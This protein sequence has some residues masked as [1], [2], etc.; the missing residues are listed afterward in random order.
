M[1]RILKIVLI[2]LL[3]ALIVIQFIKPTKNA[4]AEIATHQVT[5]AFNVPDTVHQILKVSCYDCH[6]NN[7]YY[8]WYSRFQPVAWFLDNHIVEGKKE[9]NF[10]EFATYSPRRQ[11]KKLEEIAK[12]VKSGDMPLS[13]YTL[14][15]R[16]AFLAPDQKSAI[17]NWVEN[18][19]KQMEMKYPADSLKITTE[20]LKNP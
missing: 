17:E 6:S 5:S 20:I 11:Y 18:T 9:L 10:S 4:S 3:M 12:Q 7:T 14:I 15:H 2:I 16:D 13:S 1:K 8:P 19:R